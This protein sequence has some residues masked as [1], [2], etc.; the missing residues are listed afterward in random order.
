MSNIT[1]NSADIA[2]YDFLMGAQKP[3]QL[4]GNK[5]YWV[6]RED[7]SIIYP[8]TARADCPTATITFSYLPG[9]S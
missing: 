3:L 1:D 6:S 7:Y 5:V 9:A 2:F 8:V 4:F